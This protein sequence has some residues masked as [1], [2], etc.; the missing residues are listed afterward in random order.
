MQLI[1]PVLVLMCL[2][3]S[4]VVALYGPNSD[5]VIA[6][7]KNFKDEVLKYPGIAVVEFFAPWCGHCKSLAPEYDK[8]ATALKGVVKIVAVD[9]TEATS[10]AQ[11]YQIQGFPTIKVF[12]ADK[13]S[14]TD[15]QGGRT[16]DEIVSNAM[17]SVNQLVKDRK[18]GK[19][20]SSSSSQSKGSKTDSKS[21]G[22]S[23]SSGSA[24]VQLT[25][26]NFEEL[27]MQSTDHWLV[28]FY[29]PW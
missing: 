1:V 17:K 26:D 5:V 12:G 28:E 25:E 7:D 6:N 20:S 22:G 21:S 16:S 18:G 13:K 14:P 9:A 8:A 29:A 11:K 2:A 10:L 27:V 19:A 24:V 15:Y 4:N 3:V 23:K